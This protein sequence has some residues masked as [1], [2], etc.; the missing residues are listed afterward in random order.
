MWLSD[1]SEITL[2]HGGA[3]PGLDLAVSCRE[4][5][6][7]RALC[8]LLLQLGYA[9]LFQHKYSSGIKGEPVEGKRGVTLSAYP[10]MSLVG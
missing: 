1:L 4:E 8:P 6:R 5:A 2:S 7:V 10:D 3:R 9:P